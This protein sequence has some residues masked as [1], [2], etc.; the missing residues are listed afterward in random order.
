VTSSAGP[1]PNGE[2]VSFIVVGANSLGSVPLS[3]GTATFTTSTL[4][5]GTD[6][7][8]A[9]YVGDSNFAASTSNALSEV[10]SKGN[11]STTVTASENQVPYGQAVTFTATVTSKA[12]S[13][14]NGEIVTF[15]K[16][17]SNLGTGKLSGGVA[18]FT[19]AI[20]PEGTDSIT[21]T[22]PGDANLTGSASA[23]SISVG[24]PPNVVVSA[25]IPEGGIG[26]GPH[27]SAVGIT[28]EGPGPAYNVQM[29]SA[30]MD[31]M[32]GT[33]YAKYIGT[34]QPG[35]SV[36][37]QVTWSELP[38]NLGLNTESITVGYTGGNS[39]FSVRFCGESDFCD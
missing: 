25:Q 20:L 28:N 11:S 9:I 26:A 21:A 3:G 5:A 37:F 34:L 38:L 2:A 7:V 6:S 39:T 29:T 24:S 19:I 35:Q 16:G 33:P 32:S 27:T 36:Y 17:G 10:V 18:S 13:P 12:G 1:P 4:P 22:Y 15:S 30:R 8:A 31:E 23:V 14:P